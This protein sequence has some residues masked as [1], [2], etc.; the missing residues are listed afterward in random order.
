MNVYSTL[1]ACGHMPSLH[2]GGTGKCR[3]YIDGSYDPHDGEDDPCGCREFITTADARR[4]TMTVQAQVIEFHR[5]FDHPIAESPTVP[6]DDRVRFR[7]RII[8]EEFFET[9]EALFDADSCVRPTVRAKELLGQARGILTHLIDQAG[10]D[11]HLAALADGMADLDYVVEGTRLEFGINGERIAGIVH[12]TNMA[13]L[14]V[15]GHCDG[16]GNVQ[17]ATNIR[18][19]CSHCK[20]TGKLSLKRA[21]GKTIKPE[22]WKPPDIAGEIVRQQHD[23]RLSIKKLLW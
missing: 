14:A 16:H 4:M 20:G 15:C 2:E 17:S 1:C 7:A 9:L 23:D 11:V 13:K 6:S 3:D 10:I 19:D 21:D 8:T 22:D 12:I 18:H 5:A